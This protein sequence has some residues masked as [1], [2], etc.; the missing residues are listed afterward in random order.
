[1]TKA[2]FRGLVLLTLCGAISCLQGFTSL[3]SNLS[4]FKGIYYGARCLIQGED[5]YVFGASLKVYED[6][7]GSPP[8]PSGP[9]DQIMNRQAYLPT[10]FLCVWPFA[11]LPFG[12]AHLLWMLLS[13]GSLIFAGFLIWDTAVKDASVASLVL[14]CFMLANGGILF[15]SGNAAAVTIGLCVIA[16][17][18]FFRNRF[19]PIGVICLAIGLV[20]KPHDAMLVWFFF[21]LV[22]GV[23]RKHA[24]QTLALAAALALSAGLWVTHIAPHWVHEFQSNLAAYD[25]PGGLN[26][27]GPNAYTSRGPAMVIDLQAAISIFR[28]DPRIYNPASYLVCGVICIVWIAATIRARFSL[29]RAWIALAVVAPLSLLVTYHRPYDAKLLMLTIPA[30]AYLRARRGR[31]GWLALVLTT[32][33]VIVTSDI[34]LAILL[35][36]K[37][38]LHVSLSTL[39][40]KILTVIFLRPAPFYLLMLC[41]FYLWVYLSPAPNLRKDSDWVDTPFLERTSPL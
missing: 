23:H 25:A 34:P 33:A 12:P 7:G 8:V 5:P 29:A 6:E 30:C 18:C 37:D 3:H 10:A 35:V 31:I 14:L 2:S 27:P 39:A 24:L 4:D 26:N 1:M 21:L 16:A 13:E 40:G 28:D 41:I 19:V 36:I 11:V 32:L 22:G 15:A 17:W 38:A 20:L 9:G